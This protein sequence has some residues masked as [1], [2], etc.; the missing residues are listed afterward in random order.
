MANRTAP[1]NVYAGDGTW[2]ENRPSKWQQTLNILSP[3]VTEPINAMGRLFNDPAIKY[4]FQPT[5]QTVADSLMLSGLATGGSSFASKPRN[6][7]TMGIRAYHGSPHDF[8]PVRLIEMPDGQRLYQ[9]MDELAQTPHGARVIKEYPSG[10]FDMSK[11][12]TGEGVQ[13]YGHGLYF[14][15]SEGVAKSYRDNLSRAKKYPPGSGSMYEVNID[16]DPNQ[17]LDWDKPISAQ[18]DAVRRLAGDLP[19]EAT[20]ETLHKNMVR[21]AREELMGQGGTRAYQAK[22]AEKLNAAGVPGIKFLDARSRSATA[23]IQQ[24]L[25]YWQSNLTDAET[26]LK[27]LRADPRGAKSL[28]QHYEKAAL[29]YEDKIAKLQPQIDTPTRNIVVFD[30]KLISIVRKYGIAGASAMLGYNILEN[31]SKA[32]AEELRRVEKER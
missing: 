6:A 18:P 7:M 24:E 2:V 20:G 11:I 28:I 16:A 4:G 27:K 9:N 3:Y 10:R 8:P 12:G 32:Q 13:A 19:P 25:N 21:A 26:Q 5:E 30:D 23:S 17:F 22:V 31:I 29:D 1:S 15:E 14:A